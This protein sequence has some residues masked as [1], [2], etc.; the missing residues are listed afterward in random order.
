MQY[1]FAGGINN[2][3][4]MLKFIKIL[5]LDMLPV[6]PEILSWQQLHHVHFVLTLI[7]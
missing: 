4:F 6:E 7:F 1:V 3:L 2:N 5:V